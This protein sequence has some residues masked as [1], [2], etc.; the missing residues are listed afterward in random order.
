M[1]YT[2]SVEHHQVMRY[3]P[4]RSML[5]RGG[6]GTI[7]GD[8]ALPPVC[9]EQVIALRDPVTIPWLLLSLAG[10]PEQCKRLD[11]SPYLLPQLD[12]KVGGSQ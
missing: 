3:S 9:L 6:Q 1:H 10:S 12:S 2:G 4:D 7:I 5:V 8:G 11:L